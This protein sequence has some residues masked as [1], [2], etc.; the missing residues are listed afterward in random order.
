MSLQAQPAQNKHV[1]KKTFIPLINNP[2]LEKFIS[3]ASREHD[4]Q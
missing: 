1:E 3:V 4:Q 2:T